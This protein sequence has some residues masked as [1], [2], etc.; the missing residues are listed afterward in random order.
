MGRNINART[1]SVAL[2]VLWGLLHMGLG[3]SMVISDLSD[4]APTNEMAAE[5]LL[6]FIAVTVLG[7]QA[8]YVAL[9][10]NRHRSPAGFWLNTVVLGVID[11]A[12]VVY[13][14]LP[15]HVDLLG[16]IAGPV[17]W[18]AATVCAAVA[19]KK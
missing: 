6:Y 19:L 5:S 13:L 17:I 7:A 3:A 9:T 11:V 14:V 16:G 12:F 1:V 4:G 2:Y 18:L 10:L 8:I 15:G